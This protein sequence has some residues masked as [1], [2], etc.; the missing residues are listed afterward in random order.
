M[1]T[2]IDKVLNASEEVLEAAKRP[3]IKQS[4]KRKFEANIAELEETL[5]DL[6]LQ[7]TEMFE[8]LK[9]RDFCVNELLQIETD[10]IDTTTALQ[11]LNSLYNE[12]FKKEVKEGKPVK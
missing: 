10:I 8:T 3:F 5:L 12:V 2:L 7:K 4:Q 11:A 1:V 6:K 9:N